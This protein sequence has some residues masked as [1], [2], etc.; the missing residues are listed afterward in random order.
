MDMDAEGFDY[1]GGPQSR[2]ADTLSVYLS[3]RWP[4]GGGAFG[5]HKTKEEFILKSLCCT[6]TPIFMPFSQ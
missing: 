1:P 4:A 5:G 2:V 6:K 3:W